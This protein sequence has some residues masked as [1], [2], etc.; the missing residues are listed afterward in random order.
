MTRRRWVLAALAAAAIVLVAGRALAALYVEHAWYSA[1]DLPGL[2]R[3]N[4]AG[5]VLLRGGTTLVATLFLF[6]NLYAVRRS[7]L[8]FVLPRQLGDLEFGEEVPG[9][10]L[11]GTAAVIAMAVGS[12]LGIDG[13]YW[14]TFA[15]GVDGAWFGER[16]P[17]FEHDV[18][19]YV[20][21]L[22]AE[23]QLFAWAQRLYLVTVF[24]VVLLY[25][26]TPSIRWQER[27][28]YVSE[29]VRRHLTVLGGVLLVVFAWA[30]RL[31]SYQL[32]LDGSGPGGA[33]AAV[34]LQVRVPGS[35]VLAATSLAA[36]LLVIFAGVGG[37]VRLAFFAVSVMLLLSVIVRFAL[38]IAMRPEGTQAGVEAPYLATRDGFT[39]RAFGA[40]RVVLPG[41]SAPAP[42][43]VIRQP[44]Q[45]AMWDPAALRRAIDG[46][47]G[48][49]WLRLGDQVQAVVAQ[50][51]FV[52]DGEMSPWT[53]TR[54]A[55]WTA[56]L[57]GAPVPLRPVA[58]E[59]SDVLPPV[60]VAD[61][62]P[63]YRVVSNPGGVIIGASTEEWGSRLAHA[64][65]L[66]NFRLLRAPES[67]APHTL[68]LRPQLQERIA[69]VAPFFV[70][71]RTARPAVAGDTLFWAVE[72]YTG[73]QSYPLSE[74]LVVLGRQWRY[75]HPAGHAIVNAATGAVRVVAVADPDP[76]TRTW[77]RRFPALFIAQQDLPGTVVNALL[78]HEE[79]AW[80]RALSFARIGPSARHAPRAR[81]HLALEHGA[82][83]VLAADIAPLALEGTSGLSMVIPILDERDRVTGLVISSGVDTRSA[84]VPA[85]S[86]APAWGEALDALR[87]ADS[88]AA[89]REARP[90]R[91]RVRVLPTPEGIVFAQPVYLWPT[92]GEPSL[93]AVSTR[94]GTETATAPVLQ[95]QTGTARPGAAPTPEPVP[96][97]T[98]YLRMRDAL[99]RG[100][101]TTF[102]ALFDTLGRSLD[103]PPR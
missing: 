58:G 72:L 5:A 76:I 45:V 75:F 101:W 84:W 21:W 8:S 60:V 19:F 40:D 62:A 36:G 20:G 102:G 57:G 27:A 26:L 43:L 31:E 3:A 93:V 59:Y 46:T 55:A 53:I 66:Q 70:Q 4:L 80:A 38:P 52:E 56:D 44:Q 83:S 87:A 41:D 23:L 71:G 37:Q 79:A 32:L 103:A 49:G 81:R 39:R 91:G 73:A 74:P 13:S 96:P 86:P 95:L 65:A 29:Y 28:L 15:L 89:S 88:T 24:V 1:L 100:D 97:R 51:G 50:R 98:I 64:W 25:A 6:A 94:S 34:D 18:G 7:V 22:P 12:F 85:S 67:P 82:D 61:S 90:V 35:L 63:A 11:V 92:R 54:A 10:Y 17:Y 69:L 9:R 42:P 30:F 47:A 99:R 33:F 16:D 2:A 14:P 78:P 48:V 77:M 68:V